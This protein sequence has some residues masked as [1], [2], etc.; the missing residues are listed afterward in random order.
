LVKL[1]QASKVR[2]IK[3]LGVFAPCSL[4]SHYNVRNNYAPSLINDKLVKSM[5]RL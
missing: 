4:S 3:V 2:V 5:V 1:G